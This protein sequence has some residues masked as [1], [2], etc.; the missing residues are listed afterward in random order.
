MDSDIS[1]YAYYDITTF[2]YERQTKAVQ[3]SSGSQPIDFTRPYFVIFFLCIH[4]KTVGHTSK[5]IRYF[6]T[7]I[8]DINNIKLNHHDHLWLFCCISCI[9]TQISLQFPEVTFQ[10]WHYFMHS[11]RYPNVKANCR[12]N[13]QVSQRIHCA[14]NE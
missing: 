6:V 2:T 5:C 3:Y 1:R 13:F 9:L 14:S 10:C 8:Q 4:N 7:T 12:I 11:V